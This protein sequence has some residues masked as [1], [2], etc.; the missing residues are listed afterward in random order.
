MRLLQRF[1]WG[2]VMLGGLATVAHARDAELHTF[3]CLDGCPVGA[4]DTND[5]IVRE[6]YTLSSNDLTKVA[7]WV[8]YRITPAT[9]QD[10]D[11][12]RNWKADPWL[13]DA[14]TLEPND[15]DGAYAE[16]NTDRGHQVPLASFRSSPFWPDT[17]FLSNVTAQREPLNRQ[18]WRLLEDAEREL[19]ARENTAVYVLS[20]PLFER[21]LDPMPEADERHRVPSGYWKVIATA[22]GRVAAF[23]MDQEMPRQSDYCDTE[24][25]LDHV[26]LRALLV[27]FPRNTV[28]EFTSLAAELGCD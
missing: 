10:G 15:Y 22:D 13:E 25:T 6:I 7:D 21:M 16:L 18:P 17:N 12:S 24:V 5:V 4:P 11:T 8:A 1:F 27:L 26:E 3:H 2:L 9:I 28:R 14:E 19:A 20:G 23:I